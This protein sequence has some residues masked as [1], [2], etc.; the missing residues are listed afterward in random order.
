[1]SYYCIKAHDFFFQSSRDWRE[2]DSWCQDEDDA[3]RW[4]MEEVEDPHGTFGINGDAEPIHVLVFDSDAT[5]T[6]LVSVRSDPRPAYVNTVLDESDREYEYGD[7]WA[8]GPK[9]KL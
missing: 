2:A 5:E 7:A 9:P 3:A 1:M 8:D 4:F 6:Y